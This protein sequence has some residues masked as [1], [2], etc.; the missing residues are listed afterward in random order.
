V[1][2]TNRPRI[3]AAVL[4]AAATRLAGTVI[5]DVADMT[6]APAR[7]LPRLEAFAAIDGD[8]VL[9]DDDGTLIDLL[10]GVPARDLIDEY[11]TA[12]R[13]AAALNARV[14]QAWSA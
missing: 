10:D 9:G 8:E 4:A 2:A 5:L 14:R 6:T 3:S 13:A 11:G 1:T 12:G 7:Y